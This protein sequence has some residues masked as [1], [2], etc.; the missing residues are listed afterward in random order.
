MHIYSDT[1]P[2]RDKKVKEPSICDLESQKEYDT[3]FKL[4]HE[5]QD[6]YQHK[7]Y[8]QD[9]CG[10]TGLANSTEYECRLNL[11]NLNQV[12]ASLS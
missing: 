10:S 6:D 11:L 3:M 2:K 7:L 8:D 12:S 5:I 4:Q 1:T 9:E